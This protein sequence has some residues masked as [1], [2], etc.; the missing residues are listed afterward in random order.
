[1][2]MCRRSRAQSW[3]PWSM[4]SAINQVDTVSMMLTT[5]HWITLDGLC[6]LPLIETLQREQRSF[7]K[8]LK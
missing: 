8:P 5:E 7:M 4:R 6:E 2:Q 1:M 3:L